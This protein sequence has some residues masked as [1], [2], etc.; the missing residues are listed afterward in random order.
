MQKI[1]TIAAVVLVLQLGIFAI[2]QFSGKGKDFQPPD[3]PF[4]QFIPDAVTSVEIIGEDTSKIVLERKE[5]GWIIPAFYSAPANADQVNSL[6]ARILML[7]QGFIVATSEEAVKRFKVADDSFV[8][9]VLL[10]AGDKL[11]GDFFVGTS[12]GFRQIHARKAGTNNV[13]ALALSTFELE[14]SPDQWLDK[15]LFKV[16]L[17]DLETVS[18]ANFVLTKKDSNWELEGLP[19]GRLTDTKAAADFISKVSNLSIQTLMKPQEAGALFNGSPVLQ[20]TFGKKGGTKIEL[21]LV[22]ADGD[23][24]ALKRVDGDL[25]GKV[26]KIQVEAL[27][28]FTKDSFLTTVSQPAENKTEEKADEAPQ[29]EDNKNQ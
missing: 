16:D 8:R 27:M 12:P 20:C 26:H 21:Q 7:K 2:V 9:H 22:K 13:I 29:I 14:T 5:K 24:Y 10:K 3:T 11:V 15:N 1:I 28:K 25:Y 19:E 23:F 18:F 4:L 17:T 6:L